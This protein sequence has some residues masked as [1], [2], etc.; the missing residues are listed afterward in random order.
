[1]TT[2]T[3]VFGLVEAALLAAGLHVVEGPATDLPTE[4][5]LIA[6]AVVLWPSAAL[7]DYDRMCGTRSG[8]SDRVRATCVGAT[9]RD[10][11]AV[12]DKFEA[13]VGG[14]R[15]SAKGGTLRQ[16]LATDPVV[17]PNADP[18]RVSLYV[19]YSTTTKG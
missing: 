4:G 13:A 5:G 10:A 19:E 14:M 6:Q 3:A 12:A 16:T 2:Q 8:R 15:T 17:E 7:H 11:L 18:R 9:A 1:M